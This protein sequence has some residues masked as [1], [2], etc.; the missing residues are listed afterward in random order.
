VEGAVAGRLMRWIAVAGLA[1]SRAAG[2]VPAATD[3]RQGRRRPPAPW[4]RRPWSG[5][6]GV[7]VAM[8]D[9]RR[10]QTGIGRALR[11]ARASEDRALA[12]R[13]RE[14]GERL[15]KLLSGVLAW[16]GCTPPTIAPSTS[17]CGTSAR[18][19]RAARAA[20][21]CPPPDRGGPRLRQ[22][23][24]HSARGTDVGSALSSRLRAHRA[25][26][27][28]FHAALADSQWRA[29][30]AGLSEAP[31]P[32]AARAALARNLT[33]KGLAHVEVSPIHRSVSGVTSRRPGGVPRRRWPVTAPAWSP[34]A[35]RASRR[36]ACPT[37]SRSGVSSPS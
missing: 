7:R 1:R 25:G 15:A 2:R 19:W 23:S 5:V 3:G 28:S 22:R 10:A 9:V 31:P 17:R 34:R 20:G 32:G 14:E 30:V 35:G 11:R 21:Q 12:A 18:R 13:V 16:R 27:L 29:L 6:A 26:G 33:A 24:A 36:D 8:D 4:P 37:R